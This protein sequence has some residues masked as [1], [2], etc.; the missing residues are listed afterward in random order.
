MSLD[1]TGKEEQF[2]Y[3]REIACDEIEKNRSYYEPYISTDFYLH[4]QNMKKN[5]GGSEIWATEAEILAVSSVFDCNI[6]VL[7][8]NKSDINN[9]QIFRPKNNSIQNTNYEISVQYVNGN[10]FNLIQY[11]KDTSLEKNE[12]M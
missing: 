10:H 12:H 2:N 1:L 8:E 5:K 3:V 6:K 4:V 7:I 9:W 11:N